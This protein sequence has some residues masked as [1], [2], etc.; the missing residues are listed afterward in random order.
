MPRAKPVPVQ[1]ASTRWEKF[2]AAKGIQKVKKRRVE[3]NEEK[4]EYTPTWGYKNQG[5]KD[6]DLSNW[7]K[8]VP[9]T[10]GLLLGVYSIDPNE[11]LFKKDRD[12]KKDRVQKNEMQQRRNREEATAK[13]QGLDHR[14]LKKPV[15]QKKEQKEQLRSQLTLAKKA[16]AS[17]GK[18]D[19]LEDG[20]K[21]KAG[22][23]KVTNLLV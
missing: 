23:R 7:I 13:A 21:I 10:G 1:K 6:K 9:E 17:M 16:T 18:F 4:S 19:S 20:V 14:A 8:E 3:W 15:S 5:N 2:A 22:K 12:E 11:D